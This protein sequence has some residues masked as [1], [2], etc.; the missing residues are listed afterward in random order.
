MSSRKMLVPGMLSAGLALLNV[1]PD[2]AGHGSA[3]VGMASLVE[4]AL[5][6]NPRPL[7]SCGL[8]LAML[9]AIACPRKA[10]D[11]RR[12]I[13]PAALALAAAASVLYGLAMPSLGD[14]DAILAA[15]GA[16]LVGASFAWVELRL[17]AAAMRSLGYREAAWSFIAALVLKTLVTYAVGGLPA[18]A[19]LAVLLCS[20]PGALGCALMAERG[21]AAEGEDGGA[22]AAGGAARADPRVG[23]AS[24]VLLSCVIA[25]SRGLSSL[26]S[27][28]EQTL[29]GNNS[30]VL[31]VLVTGLFALC[32]WATLTA[33]GRRPI[34]VAAVS[35]AV[36]LGGFSAIALLRSLGAPGM[37]VAVL[38]DALELYSHA[39]WMCMICLTASSCGMHP[40]RAAGIADAAMSS[41]AAVLYALSRSVPGFDGIVITASLYATAVAAMGA[42][43]WLGGR[44]QAPQDEEGRVRGVGARMGLTPRELD[45]FELLVQGRDRAFI[46]DALG[47][48]EGTVKTHASHIYKKAGV[49]NKQELITLCGARVG[50]GS[51]LG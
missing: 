8:A 31:F 26:G 28:G 11:A 40:F 30:I 17:L 24:L 20:M 41:T 46:E 45:V 37:A 2:L 47:M 39:A 23:I 18:P 4:S 43:L 13:D 12:R 14:L 7:F 5:G 50:G 48:S 33:E 9:P 19:Q 32:A 1:F 25:V 27:W 15:L 49:T 10:F 44:R 6:V 51:G 42:L 3:F 16:F 34:V 21:L 38:A 36:V 29:V 22:G 35:L